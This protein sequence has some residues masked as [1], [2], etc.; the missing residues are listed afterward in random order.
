MSVEHAADRATELEQELH[1]EFPLDLH[2]ELQ[3]D[4]ESE[5]SRLRPVVRSICGEA[6]R[7]R[8]RVLAA[9][10]ALRSRAIVHARIWLRRTANRWPY[11]RLLKESL[12]R[13]D[14][15]ILAG[16]LYGVASAIGEEPE[17]YRRLRSDIGR[18]L[19]APSGEFDDEA[20]LD[21]LLGP[22]GD[23]SAD[24]EIFPPDGRSLVTN[25]L[26]V[27]FRFVCCLDITFVNPAKNRIVFERGTGTLISDRHVLTAA[28][29]VFDN[30]SDRESAFPNLYLQAQKVV[31][32]PA[33]N[34]RV[35]PFGFSEVSKM[36]FPPQWQA[37]AARNV[38]R[39][40]ADYAL[41][42]L[43]TPLGRQEPL[44]ITMQLGPLGFWGSREQ[45]MGTRIRPIEL[46]RLR[47]QPLNLAG[48]PVDK[49]RNRPA[50]RP[51]TA[52]EMAACPIRDRGSTQWVST[53][54]VVNP[55]P[56]DLPGMITY[57]A[58]SWR[59]QSGGA[60]WLN[61]EGYRNLVAINTTAYPNRTGAI[62]AN[63]GVRITEPVLRLLRGW[64]SADGVSARF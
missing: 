42:T 16:C 58:D 9:P 35:L 61:W 28:H 3:F 46:D 20:A 2:P 62:I 31:V 52:A 37:A 13:R 6:R 36:R 41:L 45:G 63:M 12:T 19:G 32:A 56:A 14:L 11:E 8:S 26:L 29:C 60:V 34:D 39:T 49:C 51:A 43:A 30:L 24:P 64:M 18:L 17:P 59:G 10:G 40:Q 55:A 27:P 5:S 38:Y 4:I 23:G 25:T 53:D 48:Y 47:G 7:I 1:E 50:G 21:D 54:R 57:L 33:R 15:D 22:R 44:V